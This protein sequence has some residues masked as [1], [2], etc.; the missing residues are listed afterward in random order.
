MN[1]HHPAMRPIYLLLCLLITVQL[2]H[3]QQVPIGHWREHLPYTQATAVVSANGK[4]FCATGYNMF[5]VTAGDHDITRYTK[6]NGL[7]DAG[8][9]AIGADNQGRV[10]IGYSNGNL[11]LLKNEQVYNLPDILR[12]NIQGDKTIQSVYFFRGMAWVSTGFGIVVVNTDRQ[13]TADTYIIGDD[14]RYTAVYGLSADNNFIY[15]ATA[16]GVKRA[17]LSGV[18]LANYHNWTPVMQ[19][20]PAA[21]VQSIIY[22]QQRLI[23]L[24]QDK[25]FSLEQNGWEPWYADGRHI[26]TI[27]ADQQHLLVC[28]QAQATDG[29]RVLQLLPDGTIA[30][31]L[32]HP[33]IQAPM[34]AATLEGS[35]WIADSRQGLVLYEN[36]SFSSLTPNAPAGVVG[37]NMLFVNNSL[38]ATAGAVSA[39]WAPTGNRNGYFVFEQDEWH[40]FNAD[41][42]PYLD[43]ITDLLPL[44][45]DPGGSHYIGSFSK[46]LLVLDALGNHHL[47]AQPTIPAPTDDPA[48]SRVSGLAVD[49]AGNLWLSAYGADRNL[50]VKKPDNSWQQFR[51]PY[52][53]TYNALSD[54]LVD[55][56]DQKWIISPRGN[57]L[58]VF[59]HGN[60]LENTADDRWMLFRSGAAQGNLP[61]D[62]VR[63]LARDKDGWIWVGTTRGIAIFSC[64]QN[65]F[66]TGCSA[67]LPIVQQDNF[68]GYLFRDEQV[69]T[70]AVDG[71]NQKWVGTQNGVWLISSR[72]EKIL[73]H[74]NTANS[75]LPDNA[76]SR[77]AIHPLTGEVFFATGLG[78]VSFRANAT[79]GAQGMTADSVLVFPNPV[80]P[81]YGGTI[82]IRGLVQNA[83]VKITDINGRLVFETRAQGGQA[84]W[85]G[86]DYTGRRPQSGIYL[87]F[88]TDLNGTEHLATKIAFIQ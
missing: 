81:G 16:E 36:N 83:R 72:G 84:V 67:Y 27:S 5:A 37:G 64:A 17:P 74:F 55:D 29:A 60:S 35:T 2:C 46:G 80:P 76:V 13:E 8:I 14:G 33:L 6:L 66:T 19:G 21:P 15:A 69:N 30:N 9:S 39:N 25:L 26:N 20:L 79:E 78:L 63:C 49:A 34:Q 48:A 85:S 71:A 51:I 82:A 62:D 87:I 57:G 56:N 41:T 58:F 11:D 18:N 28:Q 10:L 68:A 70:I 88:A 38:W 53:H 54:I 45:A 86:K 3:A 47:V 22:L 77:I 44:A 59:N 75:P 73:A 7:H 23:C 65:V 43:T 24:Q 31:S 1:G 12:K 52:A 40:N 32:Q 61:S 4:V 50:L 42:Q